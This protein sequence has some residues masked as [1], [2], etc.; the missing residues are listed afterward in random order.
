M[1][2][3]LVSSLCLFCFTFWLCSLCPFF[4]SL[5]DL[6]SLLSCFV[7]LCQ[8]FFSLCSC[9][10]LVVIFAI[11]ELIFIYLFIFFTLLCGCFLPPSPCCNVCHYVV[12][13]CQ[14]VFHIIS[15]QLFFSCQ[16]LVIFKKNLCVLS[17]VILLHF[18]VTLWSSVVLCLCDF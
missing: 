17:L 5:C 1:C 8:L 2:C 13:L 4:V 10:H 16:L 12:I 3:D 18:F 7:C 15:L 14:F 6:S 9:C 11:F